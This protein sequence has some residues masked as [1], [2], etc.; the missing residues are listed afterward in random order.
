MQPAK[1]NNYGITDVGY[2][3]DMTNL[4]PLEHQL[5][6]AGI[7][8]VKSVLPMGTMFAESASIITYI[9]PHSGNVVSTLL[10]PTV[11]PDSWCEEY[12]IMRGVDHEAA[13]GRD[14]RPIIR[15][16]RDL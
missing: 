13:L 2:A 15:E 5:S 6:K 3:T 12:Y 9:S 16:V 11:G 1:P 8:Y 7:P 14:W 4:G 10:I